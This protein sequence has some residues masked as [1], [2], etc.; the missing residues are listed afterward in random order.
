MWVMVQLHCMR[1]DNFANRI[2]NRDVIGFGSENGRF[3][4]RVFW[5]SSLKTVQMEVMILKWKCQQQSS[6][7]DVIFDEGIP[8]KK[9]NGPIFLSNF[10]KLFFFFLN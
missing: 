10:L 1:L 2:V 4:K 3:L 7:N 9:W 5:G 8:M 6:C